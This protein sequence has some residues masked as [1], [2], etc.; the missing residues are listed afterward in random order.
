MRRVLVT[1]AGGF[2][3]RHALEPLAARGFEVITPG[4][5]EVDLLAPDGPACAVALAQP[6]HLL[7]LAWYAEHG[8]FWR[9]PENLRWIDATLRLLEAFAAAG[10]QR[11]VCAGTC[12]EYAWDGDG[13]L[14]ESTSPLRPATLYGAAKH[15]AHTAGA[16]LCEQEGIALAWGR[17][18]FL[19]GPGEHPRRLVASVAR[20]L[21]AGLEAPTSHGRQER[22]F[23]HVADAGEALAALVD[24]EVTGAVNVASG[25]PATVRGVVEEVA[26]AAQAEDLLRVG[27]LPVRED[28]PP[29]LVTR[30]ARLRDETGWRPRWRL[31][32][33]VADAVAWWRAQGVRP[34]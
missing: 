6:T 18:F 21:L 15:A 11:A 28:D 19:Y 33:G 17:V 30:A 8:R 10:G 5:A 26:R 14:E 2:I 29:R 25:E 22:D 34:R 9:A 1:G 3:G 32:D 4:R 23:L 24:A 31:D 16:A 13:D 7:H 12:A 20:N 27:A